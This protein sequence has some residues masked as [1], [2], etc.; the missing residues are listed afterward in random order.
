M[1]IPFFLVPPPAITN[2]LNSSPASDNVTL[3]WTRPATNCTIT[4]SQYFV[5]YSGSVLW[6]DDKDE[7]SIRIEGNVTETV[8]KGL[9]PYTNYTFCVLANNAM[10]NTTEECVRGVVTL[11]GSV[12]MYNISIY[13]Q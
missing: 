6:K 9:I 10:G 7:G 5:S 2:L 4:I 3:K 12:F 1:Q 13:T 8:V 11:K